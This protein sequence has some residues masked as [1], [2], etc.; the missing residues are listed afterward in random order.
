M[1]TIDNILDFIL[2]DYSKQSC[3]LSHGFQWTMF[4]QPLRYATFE[5]RKVVNRCNNVTRQAF[6]C[7]DVFVNFSIWSSRTTVHRTFIILEHFSFYKKMET[8]MQLKTWTF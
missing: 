1:E 6:V 3:H 2:K 4:F 7:P 8:H 5:V